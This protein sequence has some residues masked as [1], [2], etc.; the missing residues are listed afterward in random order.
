[1][2]RAFASEEETEG[3]HS[4]AVISDRLWRRRFDAD[5]AAVGATITLDNAAHT[6]IGVLPAGFRFPRPHVY[7]MPGLTIQSEPDVLV[8][9]VFTSA[10]RNELM[11]MFNFPVIARLKDGVT[12][13]AATAE[14]NVIAA[15]LVKTSGE[16]L[17]LRAIAKPLKDA[18]VTNSR[19]GLLVVLGAIGSVLAIACLNLAIL[20]LVRAEGRSLDA[21]IRM[22]L[23]ANRSHLLRRTLTEMLLLTILGA[24][25]GVLL[26]WTGLDTLIRIAPA[27][28]PRLDQVRIDARVL[29]FAFLLT[30]V[31][32]LACGLL[33][34]MRIARSDPEQVLRAAGHTVTTSGAALRLRNTLVTAQVALGAI[35]LITAGLL[36]SSFVRVLRAEKGFHAPTVL[37]AD[38]ML[39][40]TKYSS[41]ERRS[42]FH[43]R[44]LDRLASAP[45]VHSAASVSR[46][47]LQGQTWISSAHLAG[48]PR[49]PLERPIT[50]VR[51]ISPDYFQTMGIPVLAGRTFDERDESR[52]VVVISRQL[53]RTL[54]PSQEAIVGQR[55]ILDGS[56]EYEVIG[57]ANDVRTDAD[58]R[59]V[60]VTYR[61]YWDEPP[62]H[63]LIV[64]RAN[65]D[66]FSIADAVRQTIRDV[67]PEL[68]ISRM[69]TMRE[70]LE[71]SV[72]QRRFQ[73]LLTSTFAVCALL[74]AALGVYGVISHAVTRRTREI[75]IRMAFGAQPANVYSMVLQQG[76]RPVALGLIAGMAGAYGLTRFLRSLLYEVSSND[77]LTVCV[78]V[79]LMAVVALVAC[80]LP[81]RRAARLDPMQVLRCE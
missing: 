33:P 75:G 7:G 42:D 66:P 46:L 11:G 55:F 4:V 18:I 69:Y 21:A 39:S 48:D 63:T 73:M 31:T 79:V 30:G 45:G 3:H 14:L 26:A 74:L 2:G 20:H 51:F 22:A 10:E 80:Y 36:L 58:Q 68:P 9:K 47:P 17:E 34:A 50:N 40:G 28:I 65:G 12:R 5:P 81:A 29:T 49:P 19:R 57:V 52:K 76:A 56:K 37:T 23:G 8:P 38:V 27:D 67:D 54:W 24:G 64:A 72:S 1:L 53:A 16:D 71:T 61:P 77:P 32:T 15:Q 44:L 13:Q 6:V 43:R 25:L 78:V 59:P 41:W 60:A 70:V 62:P 35:L